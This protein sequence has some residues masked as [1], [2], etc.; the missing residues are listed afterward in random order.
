MSDY[1]H[2]A[3]ERYHR[4]QHH[5][6]M[7]V[8]PTRG[9]T[10]AD[11]YYP[12]TAYSSHTPSHHYYP[13]HSRTSTV[14]EGS[15][16]GPRPHSSYYDD[17]YPDWDASSGPSG[18]RHR[19]HRS[20][21]YDDGASNSRELD[22]GRSR[23]RPRHHRTHSNSRS[24]SRGH[25]GGGGGSSKKHHSRRSKSE[26]KLT[27]AAQAALAAG[28][29]E[30]FRVRKEPGEW[31]GDKGKRILTAAVTAGGTDGLV[32]RDPHKHE[33]RHIVESTLAGLAANHVVNGS[34]SRSRSRSKKDSRSKSLL[35]GAG[36]GHGKELAAAGLVAAAGKKA[37]DRYRSK[38]RA[39]KSSETRSS[40]ASS[41]SPSR[42]SESRSPPRNRNRDR[43]S[44]KRS[45][46]VSD[47]ISHGLAA[48]GLNG[49]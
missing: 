18:R 40:P 19:H 30:A 6:P 22:R 7:D 42:S 38:S 23:G 11:Y 26:N 8:V 35:S 20:S 37:Y 14:Q 31:A 15:T 16:R 27:Q 47:L 10:N 36:G 4:S 9:G 17:Y 28:A 49:E 13:R 5:H 46:S 39:R 1:Y 3:L 32:D 48:F 24:R 2:P 25:G 12:R 34:R 44:K 33:K 21:R 43:G 45:K 29:I 41:R